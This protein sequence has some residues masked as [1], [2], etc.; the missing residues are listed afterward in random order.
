VIGAVSETLGRV[1]QPLYSVRFTNMGEITEAGLA[2]GTKVFYSEQHSTYVFTQSLK[3]YKGSDASNMHDEEVGEEEVE[4]SDD[5]AE[6]EYKRRLKQRKVDKRGGKTQQLGGPSRGGHPLKQGQTYSNAGKGL[7]YDDAEDEGLYTPLA[8]PSGFA[9]TV[10]RNE[11]PQEGSYVDRNRDQFRGRGGG[12]RARTRGD[13]ARGDSN[14][15]SLPPQGH[16][17][18]YYAQPGGTFSQSPL[19]NFHGGY[20]PPPQG[21]PASNNFNS[22]SQ[23]EYSP[24]QPLLWPHIAPQHPYQQ[25]SYQQTFQ[26]MQ[27][28]WPNMPSAAP[29]PSGAFINPAFFNGMQTAG[30]NQFYQQGQQKD[31]GSEGPPR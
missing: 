24:Q 27:S 20:P 15:Y 2:V 6:L 13:R 29:L 18:G 5:E 25:Q 16:Q 3:A 7:N 14:G 23:N 8:R 21:P 30:A 28:G 26:N 12:V 31:Q 17:N 11:A 9:D 4:F 22:P 19:P 10:G 1:Q